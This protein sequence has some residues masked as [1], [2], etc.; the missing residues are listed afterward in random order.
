[1]II[2]HKKPDGDTFGSGLAL[3]HLCDALRIPADIVADSDL[4]AQYAFMPGFERINRQTSD[5]YSLT[6]AVDCTDFDRTGKFADYCKKITSVNIDHHKTNSY[7]CKI[8]HVVPE[9]S[10]TCEMVY[11][12]L[13]ADGVFSG[14]VT[15]AALQKIA[16]CL[17]VG[18]ST[19]TG[20]FMHSSVTAKTMLTAARLA[21]TGISV[22]AIASE[23]YRSVT[24]QKMRL[25]ERAIKSMRFFKADEICVISIFLK[26][27]AET[28]S[29]F[30]DTEGLIDYAMNLKSSRAALCV[31]E[32]ADKLFKVGFR[33]KGADVSKAAAVFGGGGHTRAAGC[34]LSGYYEDVIDR[35]IKAV[36]DEMI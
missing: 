2:C 25:I 11:D 20:H 14:G 32:H 29:V 31:T 13:A 9:L 15:A 33:S 35:L 4:P 10:S 30:A 5:R 24:P 34:V 26:D 19:D 28:G 21:E 36:S 16:Y 7:F 17:F 23:L 3:A 6:V 8:N 12:L 1:M 22:H 27:F 18:L